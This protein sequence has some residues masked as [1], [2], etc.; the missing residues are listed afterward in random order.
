MIELVE[1]SKHFGAETAVEGLSLSIEA[2]ELMVLL[3][4]S[5]C[6]KTTTL[7]M[8]NRLI[9]PTSGSV[10]IAGRD[11]R[12]LAGHELRRQIG[13]CFQLIGLFPHMSVAE[14]IGVTPR[15]L[16]WDEA[17][18]RRRV[19][20]LLVLVELATDR[21]RDLPPRFIVDKDAF[22]LLLLQLPA[23]HLA[24]QKNLVKPFHQP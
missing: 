5:G 23:F 21:F 15:L 6:G 3:G 24:R 18:I 12:D 19:D 7:K 11:T 16:G 22:R 9:E 17:R 20:E 10:R 8:V 14:N 1:L 13:Y 4:G 2:G